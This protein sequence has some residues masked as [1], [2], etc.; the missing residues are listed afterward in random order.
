MTTRELLRQPSAPKR[1]TLLELLFDVVFI[2]AL[3][4]T[5]L[6]L[7]DQVTAA[8]T[9]QL[10]L[11]LGA[12][13]WTW[14]ITTLLTDFYDPQQWPIQV[15]IATT[16]TGAII[17]AATIPMAFTTHGW[18]FAT[19]YVG[20]H[21]GRGIGL[22]IALRNHH[23]QARATRFFFWFCVSGIFWFAGAF[24]DP[25][26]RVMLWAAALAIDYVSAALR[27]PTPWIGRVP[28]NQYDKASEHLGER[29]Q[30]FIILAL[31]DLVLV[32]TLKIGIAGFSGVRVAAFLLLLATTLLFWQVYV[33]RAGALLQL[34][35][36]ERP[37]R[38]TRWGPYTH[39]L[40]LAGVV[41]TAAGF[42]LVI[43]QPTGDTP[44]GWVVVIVGGPALFLFGRIVF[45]YVSFLRLA[46]SRPVWLAVLIVV[47]PS[48]VV[49]PPVL[50]TSVTVAVLLGVAVTDAIKGRPAS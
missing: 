36:T 42:D 1:A 17:M 5:S 38:A 21:V 20:I 43:T 23:A 7:A 47:A 50:V 41:A 13:W 16:M 4:Q 19:A 22:V 39:F 32:P 15:L 28:L 30:Q 25:Q 12:V 40:I 46:K 24:A 35:I 2:A 34:A 3:A 49:L 48:T 33:H 10:V 29:Y 8:N 9:A 11:L 14:S 45:E 31:G 44:I 18:V 26:T 27:Y 6:R 37:G